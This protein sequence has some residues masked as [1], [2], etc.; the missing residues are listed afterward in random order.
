[1]VFL[2]SK[3]YPN[4]S[5][6][7]KTNHF[8]FNE[9]LSIHDAGFRFAFSLEGYFDQT[10]KNDTRYVKAL[11]NVFGKKD[12]VIFENPLPFHRCTDEDWDLFPPPEKGSV[13]SWEAIKTDPNRG[14]QCVDLETGSIEIFGNENN[15]NYQRIDVAIIPCNI[16]RSYTIS[17][18]IP[19]EC[20]HSYENQLAYLGPLNLF[21]YTSQEVFEKDKFSTE[22]IQRTSLLQNIQIDEKKPNWINTLLIKNELEDESQAVNIGFPSL[23]TF[24]DY[25]VSRP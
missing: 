24:Y 21:I 14:M 19:D 3:Q 8:D 13:D 12:G 4:V 6:V 16:Q 5:E 10:A 9:K 20:D 18:P 2:F 22:S 11:V 23:T 17:S 1:M 25:E 15:D 7:I